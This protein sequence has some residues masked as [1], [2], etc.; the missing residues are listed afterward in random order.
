MRPGTQA[1]PRPSL[2]GGREKR[3]VSQ[4]SAGTGRGF[5]GNAA[6]P[7]PAPPARLLARDTV[8]AP[9]YSPQELNESTP[10]INKLN[11]A[12]RSERARSENITDLVERKPDPNFGSL[13]SGFIPGWTPGAAQD[14]RGVAASGAG[15][16][17]V[18]RKEEDKND[19]GVML[20]GLI[21]GWMK[22]GDS[23]DAALDA[24]NAAV[25]THG[26]TTES[27][28]QRLGIRD[29][30]RPLAIAALPGSSEQQV[31]RSLFGGRKLHNTKC[32]MALHFQVVAH[33]GGGHLVPEHYGSEHGART[34]Q[35]QQQQK[36]SAEFMP[37]QQL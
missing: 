22:G 6:Q 25:L 2:V 26:A 13:L 36:N 35:P 15:G 18:V 1:P 32:L 28:Q 37:W 23:G 17:M 21:P 11:R 33:R 24:G 31:P 16:D 7:W 10:Q 29:G 3:N 30:P 27:S 5:S 9:K 20:E 8:E 34:V 12:K 14:D 4:A 19:V